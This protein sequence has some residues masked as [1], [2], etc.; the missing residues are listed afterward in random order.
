[1]DSYR[2]GRTYGRF[3]HR[4]PS[5]VCGRRSP[6]PTRGRTRARQPRSDRGATSWACGC[7]CTSARADTSRSSSACSQP[8]LALLG[9]YAHSIGCTQVLPGLVHL[10]LLSFRVSCRAG[11]WARR[12][13]SGSGHVCWASR[14]GSRVDASLTAPHPLRGC[15]RR[16]GLALF[17][18]PGPLGVSLPTGGS[19]RRVGNACRACSSA[20]FPGGPTEWRCRIAG[21]FHSRRARCAAARRQCRLGRPLRPF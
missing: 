9:S 14:A 12:A 5:S 10:C 4:R 11:R 1:M 20:V 2:R 6:E 21:M 13:A 19:R 7:A 8:R 18:P 16:A 17:P 15:G 3:R